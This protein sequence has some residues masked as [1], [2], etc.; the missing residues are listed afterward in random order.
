MPWQFRLSVSPLILPN[1]SAIVGASTK[2]TGSRKPE[3]EI[4]LIQR[5]AE[6]INDLLAA[7]LLQNWPDTP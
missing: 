5:V 4:S 7:D 2:R 1:S 3:V 6:Q